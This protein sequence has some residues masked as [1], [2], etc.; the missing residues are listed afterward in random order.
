M[1]DITV[2]G[3]PDKTDLLFEYEGE[4]FPWP[5]CVMPWCPARVCFGL[6]VDYCFPHSCEMRICPKRSV[7]HGC[8]K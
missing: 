7:R 5:F 6:S 4:R 3:K 1:L 8:S 2:R